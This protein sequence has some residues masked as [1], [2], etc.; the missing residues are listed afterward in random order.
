MADLTAATEKLIQYLNEAYGT[1]K[2]LETAL[3]AHIS[4]ATRATYKKRLQAAS[5][6]NQAP[7]ARGLQA[8]QAA[9]RQG[10]GL[11]AP[12]PREVTGAAQ[13]VVAPASARRPRPG[14]AARA[15][16]HREAEKQLKNAKTEYAS[17]AEEIATY[18]AIETLAEASA[19]ATPRA[20]EVDPARGGAHER[21]PGE[22]DLAHGN[23]GDQGRGPRRRA[24][25]RH[26]LA[27]SDD[28]L[29]SQSNDALQSQ[30]Q[31][32]DTRESDESRDT[33]ESQKRL[34][35]QTVARARAA[36]A[37]AKAGR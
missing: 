29:Q 22:G 24:R 36:A 20:G 21:L 19:T 18:T 5:G 6:R 1:E 15:A 10:R 8:H 3:T 31:S 26:R 9:W 30:S 11:Q 12:G 23:G 2:R 14:S 17:E 7:R 25:R 27:Q 32:R 16:R 28:A 34:A 13:T 35:R 37:K 33:R 4:M